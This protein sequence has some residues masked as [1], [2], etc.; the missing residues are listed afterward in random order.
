MDTIDRSSSNL[1]V[2]F[3]TASSSLPALGPAFSGD[4]A[5][6]SSPQINSRTI[7]RGLTRYWWQILLLWLVVS[8][9]IVY[10]IKLLVKPTYEAYSILRIEPTK[11]Q[12]FASSIGN[13]PAEMRSFLPYLQTQANL[14]TTDNVLDVAVASSSVVSL[15]WIK[16]S[17]DPK[18]DLR[19]DLQVKIVDGAYLI[20][21][22]LELADGDQA[23]KIVNAVIAAYQTSN[24]DYN[25]AANFVLRKNLKEQLTKT[26]A[27]IDTNK[28]KLRKYVKKGTVETKKPVL[29]QDVL[30]DEGSTTEP[31]FAIFTESQVQ[32]MV[33]KMN[34]TR[35]ELTDAEA[36]LKAFEEKAAKQANGQE[37]VESSEQEN[38][39]LETAILEEFRKDP[40]VVALIDAIQE[41][42]KEL[43]H[44]KSVA[45]QHND[46]ARLATVRELEKLEA[47][48]R[49]V[50]PE[51][52]EQI[53]KR[54]TVR[55]DNSRSFNTLD[56]L[57]L[58]VRTLRLRQQDEAQFYDKVKTE[59]TEAH[60]DNFEATFLNA[61]VNSLMKRGEQISANLQQLEF[62]AQQDTFRVVRVDEATAPKT[63][64]NN[65][66]IKYMLA[67]PVGVLFMI[68]GL[69]MLLE[70]KAGRIDDPDTLS[71]R[72]RSEVYALPPLP[73]PRS[74]RKLSAPQADDQIQQFI[75][76]LDH[77]RFA[78]CGNPAE[79]G[80]GRCVLITSAIGGEGKTTLAAQLAA[81]CGDAG[82]STLLIDAD[83]HRA[84]LCRKLDVPE[85][86]GLSDV[87]QGS[88]TID[89][90][91]IPVHAGAFYLLR[92]GN[93]IQDTS[94]VLQ[95]QSF[96]LLI[97]QLRQLY[98]LI[99]IDSPPVLP[100]PDALILGQWAD[101]AVLAARYDTSRFPQVERARRQ[102]DNAG[103]AV[104]GTVINGMRNSDKYH[105]RYTYNR[106]RSSEPNSSSTI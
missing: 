86:P 28:N 54:L 84:A 93:P 12:I 3:P 6:T 11:H 57:R 23:A 10:V 34:K 70:I 67:A 9:P 94:R 14:L 98:D 19:K 83:L 37:G 2:P 20:R 90:V 17:D 103:I 78:V 72:V 62:D 43:A 41:M 15:P 75:Q 97:T 88:A 45:R 63:P 46:P 101:G 55:T 66:H 104:L 21:V 99:I 51:K 95:S 32:Q 92:A 29:N 49:K 7:L 73:T 64:T 100:V 77:L 1:P 27:E 81:R 13:D 106:R 65:K 40:D 26:V 4:L 16:N 56:D 69:F 47:D 36:A 44:N 105:G 24:T 96:G 85:G 74:M 76:R 61:E 5:T 71:S 60:S 22:A 18:A 80:K 48:Y 31:T 53:R 59:Q 52:H 35:F 38:P 42:R 91:A 87:L 8:A 82:M 30:K 25:R 102:L 89:D 33:D 39:E 58:K 68:L 50:W 79:L